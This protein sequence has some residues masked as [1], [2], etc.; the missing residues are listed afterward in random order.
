MDYPQVRCHRW[1]W[2]P[3]CS[4]LRPTIENHR[5]ELSELLPVKLEELCTNQ[6]CAWSQERAGGI[7]LVPGL[8]GIMPPSF[9]FYTVFPRVLWTRIHSPGNL[10]KWDSE[11]W[12]PEKNQEL[13]GNSAICLAPGKFAIS[14]S[15]VVFLYLKTSWHKGNRE[16]IPLGQQMRSQSYNWGIGLE[17]SEGRVGSW[18]FLFYPSEADSP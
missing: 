16:I 9:A 3:Q 8:T 10:F 15:T 14:S 2:L 13:G 7:N 17:A 6:T 12:K 1:I 4:G 18:W 5:D 11:Y